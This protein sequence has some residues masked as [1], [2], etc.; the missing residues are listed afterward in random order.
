MNEKKHIDRLFQEK[1][2][3]FEATPN[4]A[5]W[6]KVNTTLHGAGTTKKTVPVWWKWAGIAAALVVLL[7]AGSYFMSDSDVILEYTKSVDVENPSGKS[8]AANP[9]LNEN[10]NTVVVNED[11]SKDNSN[12]RLN[13]DSNQ[14]SKVAATPNSAKENSNNTKESEE[15]KSS[16]NKQKS[17]NASRSVA[18][19][20]KSGSA[21]A[22]QLNKSNKPNLTERV[23]S[24]SVNNSDK[25]SS[26][27]SAKDDSKPSSTVEKIEGN[28]EAP[29][30]RNSSTKINEVE[31]G[32][33]PA[34]VQQEKIG[35]TSTT[36]V[37]NSTKTNKSEKDIADPALII[38]EDIKPT[39]VPTIAEN[40]EENGSSLEEEVAILE[41]EK[42]KEEVEKMNRWNIS[43]NVSPV[44]FN[45]F[46]DGS[47]ID[48]QFT[49]N[50]KSGKINFSYG[51]NGS[52]ALND[53][54]KLRAG[55][56]KVD[57]GYSTNQV[58]VYRNA[59]TRVNGNER[60]RYVKFKDN[61]A[62]TSFISASNLSFAVV[63]D[64]VANSLKSS[65]D[66]EIGFIEI[67]LEVEYALLKKRFGIN[68]IGG[69][70]TFF[71]NKNEIYS[72]LLG[73]RTLLGEANNINNTSYSANLGVGLNFKFSESVDLN[74]EPTF[75][76]QFET[77][78]ESAGKFQPYFIGI[79]SGIRFK[80]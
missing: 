57:L 76:Y 75:K 56:N 19:S 23:S 8:D 6:E 15:P 39:D 50:S 49:E 18:S 25:S 54:F 28:T 43:P 36:V 62:N 45:S 74:L 58:I 9:E 29:V 14:T 68:V 38:K 7:S 61:Q 2:K 42:E 73:D 32:K 46:G 24:S 53:R 10:Q 59:N 71:L 44:Y 27:A 41:E 64:V 48:G 3:N 79:Y 52:Y 16:S 5:V 22:K 65:I 26:V 12:N 34:T 72:S 13:N 70:S 11:S 60:L 33:S 4:D 30:A 40:K 63:P 55:V 66:Q 1:F 20:N 31:K 17:N 69:F 80:F 21:S 77:F 67:P 51:I 78:S 37:E 35:E 47:S